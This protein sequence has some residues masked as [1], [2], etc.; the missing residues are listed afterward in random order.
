MIA[1]NARAASW[2]HLTSARFEAEDAA[3]AVLRAEERL[4]QTRRLVHIRNCDWDT[5]ADRELDEVASS[6]EIQQLA[7]AFGQQLA[8]AAKFFTVLVRERNRVVAAVVPDVDLCHNKTPYAARALTRY[9][10]G[11]ILAASRWLQR[12]AWTRRAAGKS[13]PSGITRGGAV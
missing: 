1:R 13:R 2:E 9:V 4:P 8:K 3:S 6:V 7:S 12:K 10:A 11:A 5:G